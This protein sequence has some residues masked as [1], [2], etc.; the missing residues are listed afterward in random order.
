LIRTC[1][2]KPP[3][4]DWHPFRPAPPA[5][6]CQGPPRR[7]P[8]PRQTRRAAGQQLGAG[9]G[10]RAPARAGAAVSH[11]SAIRRRCTPDSAA[12]KCHQPSA[13]G[14]SP[15]VPTGK[16]CPKSSAKG[17]RTPGPPPGHAASLPAGERSGFRDC[18]VTDF[19][20]RA[21]VQA[22]T[23]SPAQCRGG[24]QANRSGARRRGAGD[25]PAPPAGPCRVLSGL[26]WP[27]A[28]PRQTRRAA[29]ASSGGHQRRAG[30]GRRAPTR[31]GGRNARP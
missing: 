18:H 31:A 10:R 13:A 9:A 8:V 11:E 28:V 27:A 14:G 6:P 19:H 16:Q 7:P 3:A 5:G 21:A 2:A 17:F 24:R 12:T 22:G 23:V 30:A 20:P 4:N 29:V 1:T 26:A 25:R 15:R